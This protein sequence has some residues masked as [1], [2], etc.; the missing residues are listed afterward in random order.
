MNQPK[1]RQISWLDSAEHRD[2]LAKHREALLGF[3]PPAAVL[4]PV[5]QLTE[6]SQTVARAVAQCAL[7]QGLNREPVVDIGAA[8]DAIR[9][10]AEYR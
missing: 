10:T 1:P 3:F 8:I 6:F 4:P 9:W 2:W 5:A 7:E